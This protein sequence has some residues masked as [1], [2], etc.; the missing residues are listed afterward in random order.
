MTYED[1][2]ADAIM[3]LAVD[4]LTEAATECPDILPD[5]VCAINEIPEVAKIAA[6]AQEYANDHVADEIQDI[7]CNA[8]RAIKQQKVREERSA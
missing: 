6:W 3:E 7:L 2:F 4:L 5:D 8:D 1:R